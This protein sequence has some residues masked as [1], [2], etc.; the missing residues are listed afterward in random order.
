M[1]RWILTCL[2]LGA[3]NDPKAKEEA[4]TIAVK[5]FLKTEI[6]SLCAAAQGIADAAPA[7]AWSPATHAADVEAMKREWK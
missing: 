6:T 7:V 2:V 3:C 4:A 5:S 1:K